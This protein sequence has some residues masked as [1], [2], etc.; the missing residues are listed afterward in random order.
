MSITNRA[1]LTLASS[2]VLLGAT[3]A[4]MPSFAASHSGAMSVMDK[5]KALAENRKKG[6]CLACHRMG[7]GDLPGNIGPPLVAMKAR[8]PDKAALRAQIY[9]ATVRNPDSMM[10]PFGRH[11]A[12]SDAEIDAIVEYVYSL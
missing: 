1:L 10:P 6:N 4:T 7:G 8:F 12:L 5:G 9:D 2:A 11:G 3:V